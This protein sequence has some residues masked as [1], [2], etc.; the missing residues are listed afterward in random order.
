MT[1]LEAQGGTGEPPQEPSQEC[2]GEG[3]G[4]QNP[5]AKGG[6]APLTAAS[7][8]GDGGSGDSLDTNAN[9][10]GDADNMNEDSDEEEPEDPSDGQAGKTYK[11][12]TEGGK[13]MAEI[14]Q[15]FC[16][17]LKA[18]THAIVV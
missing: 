10:D 12:W 15:R 7:P 4:G 5:G 16:L 13:A 8:V 2:G 3:R 17:L 9:E 1:S 6:R 14:L 11:S 18:N